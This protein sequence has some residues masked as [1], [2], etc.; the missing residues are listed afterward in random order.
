MD[1]NADGVEGGLAPEKPNLHPRKSSASLLPSN[2]HLGGTSSAFVAGATTALTESIVEAEILLPNEESEDN[3]L[4]VTDLGRFSLQS[5]DGLAAVAS[6][7]EDPSDSETEGSK[8]TSMLR[9]LMVYDV[10]GRG[11]SALNQFNVFTEDKAPMDE[12]YLKSKIMLDKL[13]VQDVFR[14]KLKQ[15]FILSTAGKPIYSMNGSDDVIMGYMG[16]ITTIVSTFQENMRTEFHHISQDGF[17]MVVMN[18]SPLLFVAVSRVAYELVPSTGKDSSTSIIENHLKI[19]HNYL[20]AVLSKPVIT[21]NFENRM[22]YDLRKILSAQDYNVLDTLSMKLTYGFATNEDGELVLD[23]NFFIASLLGSALQCA[24]ITNTTRTRLN[25]IMLSTRKLKVKKTDTDGA[26]VVLDKFAAGEKERMLASD[27]LFGLLTTEEKVISYL[28]PKNHRLANMDL[29]TL[30][31]TITA[32]F[33]AISREKSADLWI[34]FCMP[35]FNNS[36]FLYLYVRKFDLHK[37]CRAPITIVL[38]SGNK[39]SFYDMKQIA[40]YIVYKVLKNKSFSSTLSAE[41][42]QTATTVPLLKEL[43]VSV[44]KHFIYKRKRFNQ[45]YMD[46]LRLAGDLENLKAHFHIVYFYT[47]L[48]NS[49]ATIVNQGDANPKKLTY[50]RWQLKDGWVTGFMLADEKY[51]FYCLCGGSVQAQEIINQSLR[52]IKWCDRYKKRLFIGEGVSF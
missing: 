13:D 40:D 48:F 37:N 24:K 1:Q 43:G 2:S 19:L 26:S 15:F 6:S 28:R 47:A 8:L 4:H 32:S 41:L 42:A 10:G 38:L 12:E 22:N 5:N 14:H 30:L 36:G 25:S 20:L 46:D 11:A 16:L 51:E 27:L 23:S 50:T 31:T 17:K 39:N 49:K 7:D 45:F 34:P 3:N 35:N 29:H 44:I 18:K 21:R 9:D 52:I 33:K